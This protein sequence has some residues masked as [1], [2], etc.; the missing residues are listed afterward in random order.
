MMLDPNL[1]A[2]HYEY[3]YVHESFR[4]KTCTLMADRHKGEKVTEPQ[5]M[6]N[7]GNKAIGGNDGGTTHSL[8]LR[9]SHYVGG[10]IEAN[11]MQS[12]PH[13][14]QF[15][16]LRHPLAIKL[17]ENNVH[18]KVLEIP[19]D[20]VAYRGGFEGMSDIRWGIISY[21][22]AKHAL[23]IIPVNKIRCATN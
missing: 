11:P 10:R 12:H 1:V 22:A 14:K 6:G 20:G 21:L 2:Y 13:D 23:T 7:G 17:R 5:P 9:L 4:V 19:K 15:T 16:P 8:L 18:Y 3:F